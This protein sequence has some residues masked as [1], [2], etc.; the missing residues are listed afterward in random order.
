MFKLFEAVKF[1][2]NLSLAPLWE[3]AHHKE[4]LQV[5]LAFG[6]LNIW[7]H[8]SPTWSIPDALRDIINGYLDSILGLGWIMMMFASLKRQQCLWNTATMKAI[9]PTLNY[10]RLKQVINPGALDTL[11]LRT[12]KGRVVHEI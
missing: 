3:H 12:S 7:H 8:F 5:L 11:E 9:S 6:A 1:M 10:D 4:S 2:L